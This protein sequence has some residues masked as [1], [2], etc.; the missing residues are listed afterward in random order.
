MSQARPIP[1]IDALDGLLVVQHLPS[2]HC[3]VVGAGKRDNQ[4]QLRAGIDNPSDASKN[5]IHFAK[6]SESIDVNR[7]QAGGLRQQFFVVHDDCSPDFWKTNHDTA[8]AQLSSLLHATDKILI[9]S[10]SVNIIVRP[11]INT[12]FQFISATPADEAP[13]VERCPPLPGDGRR[14]QQESIMTLWSAFWCWLIFNEIYVLYRL[15]V[16]RLELKE[17]PGSNRSNGLPGI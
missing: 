9:G 16:Y 3:S 13:T 8:S 6:R 15:E 1:D 5:P 14:R 17:N 11:S 7:L 2:N 12:P 4:I 10:R